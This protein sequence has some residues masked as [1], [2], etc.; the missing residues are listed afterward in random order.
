M[1]NSPNL[2]KKQNPRWP[3]AAIL[4]FGLE[5][6]TFERLEADTSNLAQG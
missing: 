3:L 2:T 6:I 1:A 4:G 5:A